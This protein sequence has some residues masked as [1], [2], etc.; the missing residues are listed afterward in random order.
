M[1]FIKGLAVMEGETFQ[2]SRDSLERFIVYQLS[3][4]YQV[5]SLIAQKVKKGLERMTGEELAALNLMVYT[6]K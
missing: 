3:R 2:E 6:S 1:K 4:V 5:D